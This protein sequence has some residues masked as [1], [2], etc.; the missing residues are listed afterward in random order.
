MSK[1]VAT[2]VT[3]NRLSLLIE[4]IDALRAQTH[5]VTQILVVNN[6]STDGTTEWLASQ[7]DIVCITQSNL[8]GAGGFN[9]AIKYG[10]QNGYEWIWCMDDDG[11]PKEDALQNLLAAEG[12]DLQLMNCAVINKEDKKSFVWNTGGYKTL[13]EVSEN[14]ITG[15][16]HPFNGTFINRR[17]VERVGLPKAEFFLWGDE[18]E[19]YYR[20]TKVN[21]I[22]VITVANSIHYHPAA[23]FSVK[24]N[25][26]YVNSWKMYYYIRN[27]FNIAKTQFGN[28]SKAAI[29]YGSFLIALCA[30]ILVF[31]KEDK[32]KKIN[33][34][35]WSSSHAINNNFALVP[36]DVL[37]QLQTTN[38]QATG[39]KPI[40]YIKN[41]GNLIFSGLFIQKVKQA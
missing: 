18:T 24:N 41:F 23:N 28:K 27:R 20:I 35:F 16:G 39:F 29:Y 21:K 10:Y 8:G 6:G 13:D 2:V 11:L 5:P 17:I 19:Y 25:W 34:L 38:Q 36:K 12:N 37:N 22:P 33:F 26:D 7:K 15:I 14:I 31:Q 30:A 1:I 4:C 32:L 40:G 3:Y 9:T